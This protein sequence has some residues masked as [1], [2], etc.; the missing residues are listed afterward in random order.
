MNLKNFSVRARC[1][2]GNSLV[3]IVFSIALVI[4]THGTD[5]NLERLMEQKKDIENE[6]V[7]LD[8][9]THIV[10]AQLKSLKENQAL[11]TQREVLEEHLALIVETEDTF[12]DLRYWLIDLAVS[13]LN[14]SEDNADTSQAELLAHI[15]ELEAVGIEGVHSLGEQVE[16]LH[17]LFIEATDAY[18]DD[19]R[20]LGN[21]LISN[22]RKI[23]SD[24]TQQINIIKEDYQAQLHTS[25]QKIDKAIDKIELLGEESLILNQKIEEIRVAVSNSMQASEAGAAEAKGEAVSLLI[26]G[27]LFSLGIAWWLNHSITKFLIEPIKQIM[28]H[29]KG[30]E[31]GKFDQ[32]IEINRT[33][34]VGMLS[35]S[36]NAMTVRLS[37]MIKKLDTSESLRR[38]TDTIIEETHKISSASTEA[39]AS[40]EGMSTSIT[41][42]A[43]NC[44]KESKMATEAHEQAQDARKVMTD[45]SDGAQQINK[46]VEIIHSIAH[47]T[48]LLA[49]NATIEAAR[50]GEAGKGFEVVASEVKSLAKQCTDATKEIERQIQAIQSSTK[51]SI[52]SMENISQTIETLNTLSQGIAVAIEEQSYAANEI[53]QS[54]S[55][56]SHASQ[57]LAS[58]AQSSISA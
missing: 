40:I 13:L 54:M 24:I 18:A 16:K 19:R 43:R 56:V 29:M 46:I 10:N 21:T 20:V 57:T 31:A 17:D 6:E 47:Q 45:L 39:T 50:A 8:Q 3:I 7:L 1:F 12:Q 55:H 38:V 2:L 44:A 37:D 36:V 22:A 41:E 30:L 9:Q 27:I 4:L 15:E 34:E 33:D 51:T 48:D 14:E 23:S 35:K 26:F 49:V 11:I 32:T 25:N 42:V 52:D 28:Q 58:Q 53:T 5:Q